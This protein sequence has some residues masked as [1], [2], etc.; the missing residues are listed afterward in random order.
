MTEVIEFAS[1]EAVAVQWLNAMFSA[2]GET[3]KARTK[4][5]SGVPGRLVLVT[6]TGGSQIS[7]TRDNPQITYQVYAED[8]VKAEA[9]ANKVRAYVS[10]MEQQ[11]IAGTWVTEVFQ[12]GGV[13]N[14]P[15]FEAG[16]PRYQFTMGFQTKGTGTEVSLPVIEGG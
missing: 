1:A 13:V 9:L 10:A 14:F 11:T 15:D 5:P 3:A 6:R 8:E 16:L 4:M 7:K 12:I 2:T